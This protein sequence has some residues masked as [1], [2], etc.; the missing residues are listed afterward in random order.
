MQFGFC[1]RRVPRLVTG[2]EK[3]RNQA[4][5]CLKSWPDGRRRAHTVRL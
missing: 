3:S 1:P 5:E 4:K 2:A